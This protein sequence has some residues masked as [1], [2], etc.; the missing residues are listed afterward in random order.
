MIGAGA[1]EPLLQ[2]RR[3]L[4]LKNLDCRGGLIAPDF[5]MQEIDTM[6]L[7]SQ[8]RK[9]METILRIFHGGPVGVEAVAHTMNPVSSPVATSFR[10]Q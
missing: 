3:C 9:Y 8:D 6:G 5:D 2:C 10:L 1:C 7:D 4:F